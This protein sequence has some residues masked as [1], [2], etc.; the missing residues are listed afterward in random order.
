MYNSYYISIVY[1]IINFIK[2][3]NK[4]YPFIMH[5]YYNYSLFSTTNV[6]FTITI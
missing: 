3:V 4:Y 2:F 5:L 6:T 1:I